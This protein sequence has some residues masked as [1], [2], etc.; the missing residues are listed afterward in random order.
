MQDNAHLA[1]HS[2]L[3][4]HNTLLIMIC[5]LIKQDY[6][7][8]DNWTLYFD[9]REEQSIIKMLIEVNITILLSQNMVE[10][11]NVIFQHATY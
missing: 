7:I 4:E 10:S 1:M 11:V 2:D 6:H 8:L 9:R 5:K 3:F